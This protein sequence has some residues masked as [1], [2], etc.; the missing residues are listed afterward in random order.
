M[1][2]SSICSSPILKRSSLPMKSPLDIHA[3]AW[4]EVLIG[5]VEHGAGDDTAERG[6]R[7]LGVFFGGGDREEPR[8]VRVVDVFADP[9]VGML[10]ARGGGLGLR[11]V[12][13]HESETG[14]V[15]LRLG[16]AACCRR[17]R[18]ANARPQTTPRAKPTVQQTLASIARS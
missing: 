14:A 5:A 16:G 11:V 18:R 7:S 12:A 9:V 3:A 8:D 15:G 1:R 4:A 2:S 13:D 17:S 6:D 10:A